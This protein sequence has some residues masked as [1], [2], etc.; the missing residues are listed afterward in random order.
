[1]VLG[2][3]WSHRLDEAERLTTGRSPRPAAAGRPPISR[4]PCRC[5]RL[6][7][8]SAGR[9]RDAEADARS[10]LAAALDPDWLFASGIVPLV[11]TLVDQGRADEAMTEFGAVVT[12]EIPEGPPMLALVLA[13][14]TARAAR[15]EHADALGDWEEALR[16]ARPRGPT[17]GWIEDLAV[18]ADVH[19]ATGDGE[20]AEALAMQASQLAQDWGTP[21]ARGQALH[22]RA[23][24]CGG[25][26]RSICC[27]EPSTCSPRARC[28]SRTP[29]P[30]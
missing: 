30:A 19:A 3:R 16:R 15:R 10:A 9:L 7:R 12:R 6:V 24:V 11:L 18:I 21:G 23:R 29:A 27:G 14:M 13:R 20:A 26:E 25:G 5:A 28:A 8:R 17:A 2:L 4:P 22:A 1:M